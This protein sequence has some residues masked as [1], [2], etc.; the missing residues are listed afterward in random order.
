[1]LAKRVAF[2]F[3]LAELRELNDSLEQK[4]LS[5]LQVSASG[6][7]SQ[8]MSVPGLPPSPMFVSHT[9]PATPTATRHADYTLSKLSPRSC[10][11]LDTNGVIFPFGD[12]FFLLYTLH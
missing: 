9:A 4:A 5:S 12:V 6:G 11:S 2:L 10:F 8:R 1:M 7:L 3:R